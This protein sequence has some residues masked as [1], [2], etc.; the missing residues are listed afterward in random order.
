MYRNPYADLC[1]IFAGELWGR[2]IVG[3]LTLFSTLFAKYC[4]GESRAESFWGDLWG[5]NVT[6]FTGGIKSLAVGGELSAHL[7]ITNSLSATLHTSLL[8]ARYTDDSMGC[9]VDYE[10]GNIL[11]ADIPIRLRGR[12]SLSSPR[13]VAALVLRYQLPMGWSLGG[14]WAYVGGRYMEP[15]FYLSSEEVLGRDLSPE[16]YDAIMK[17][18]SLGNAHTVG[19]VAYRRSGALSFTFAVRNLLNST[20]AYYDGYQPSR[21]IVRERAE[22]VDYKPHAPRYQHIYPRYFQMTVGYEF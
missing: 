11:F 7:A 10:S 15:S 22:I 21:L 20:S 2:A 4:S 16:V 14:E 8:S 6:L 18:H 17:P 9:L 5:R 12:L 19:L 13:F 3:R 1:H